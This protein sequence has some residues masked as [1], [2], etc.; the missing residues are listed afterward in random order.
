MRK[1][2][3]LYDVLRKHGC[4]NA[5]LCLPENVL[6]ASGM[7]NLPNTYAVGFFNW[8]LPLAT[9]IINVRDE[10]ETLLVADSVLA[11]AKT[12]SFFE[13]IATYCPYKLEEKL[14]PA[15]EYVRGFKAAFYETACEGKTAVEANLPHVIRLAMEEV[16]HKTEFPDASEVLFAS[17]MVKAPWE[18][19]RMKKA[20][21]ICD[22]AFNKLNELSHT[23]VGR[24]ELELWRDIFGAMVNTAGKN[25]HTSGELLTGPRTFNSSYPGGPTDRVIELGD[26]G[27]M[28]MSAR[29][30]GYW[31]DC[32][33]IASFGKKND[34]QRRLFD[35]IHNAYQYMMDAIKPGVRACDVYA[36]SEK[37]YT[38]L[39]YSCPHYIGHAIGTGLNDMPKIIP[40]DDTLIE[41]GMTFSM[42]PGIYRENMGLRIEKML[43]V[44]KDGCEE[45]NSF[46][47][48]VYEW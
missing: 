23:G 11:N 19:E 38:E 6:H 40:C 20:A 44:T 10:K 32:C 13:N 26:V 48:G 30:M 35:V 31:C 15:Q 22:A 5:V 1:N 37:A 41:E 28:D 24:T 46:D 47:W 2:Q 8:S 18:V 25:V 12:Y 39:G 36:A 33:N 9:V 16:W 3:R 34:T 21:Q 17:K 7:V 43:I 42:E 45:F 4:D 27:I 29:Y 14:N